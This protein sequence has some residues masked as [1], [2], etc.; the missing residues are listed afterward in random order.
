MDNGIQQVSAE[1][2]MGE[3]FKYSSDLRSITQGRG[4][5]KMTFERYEEAPPMIST[6]IIEE[7]KKHMTEEEDNE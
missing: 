5:F 2:P 4:N 1:V 7:A 6:K 3:M